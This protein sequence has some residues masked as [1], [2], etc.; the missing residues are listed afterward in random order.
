MLARPGR[1]T[2]ATGTM[3]ADIDLCRTSLPRR[4]GVLSRY[5]T[6]LLLY[7]DIGDETTILFEVTP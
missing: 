1:I 5:T 7:D 3:R 2:Q 6:L 4:F